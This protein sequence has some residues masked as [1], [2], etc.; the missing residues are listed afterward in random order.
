MQIIVF[1]NKK[2]HFVKYKCTIGKSRL[3][4]VDS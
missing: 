1:F 2:I 3:C 4:I